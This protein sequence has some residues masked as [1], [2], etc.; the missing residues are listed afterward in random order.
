MFLQKRDLTLLK[1]FS[2]RLQRK[3]GTRQL[4]LMPGMPSHTFWLPWKTACMDA[5]NRDVLGSL[6]TMRK[7]GAYAYSVSLLGTTSVARITCD[8]QNHLCRP[9]EKDYKALKYSL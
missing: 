1:R 3:L 9:L 8:D 7:K 6:G 2:T 4:L 5:E